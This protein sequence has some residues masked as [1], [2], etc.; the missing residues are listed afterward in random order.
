MDGLEN[1]LPRFRVLAA[2]Y[3]RLEGRAP[4]GLDL[5]AYLHTKFGIVTEGACYI[6]LKDGASPVMLS[7]GSCYLLPRGNAFRVR[8]KADGN[9]DDFEDALKHLDG[10]TLRW[11][12]SGEVTTVIGG[13][14]IFAG[15]SYPL[16][17]DLLP[18]LVHFKVSDQELAALESTMQLLENEVVSPTSGSA[19]MLDRLAD[20]FFIQTLRACLLNADVRDTGWIGALADEKLGTAIRLI[21]TQADHPWTIESLASKTGMSRAVFAARFKKKVG[22]SP[23]SYLTRHR[24]AHA[25]ELLG[26]TSLSIAQVAAKVGYESESAF[27]KAF[28]RELGLPP[29][30]WR[31]RSQT[32]AASLR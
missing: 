22:T 4:W 14:F 20:I 26:H 13:R 25:R 7:K 24:L 2:A 28:K 31:M 29:A 30:T 19:L 8:D 17:L 11:G 32:R 1:F 18:P 23:I 6:D 21:H 9:A 16:M 10:R 5:R 15:E 12:G 27:N 3:T